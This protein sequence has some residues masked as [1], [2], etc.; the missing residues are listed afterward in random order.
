MGSA[1]PRLGTAR[2]GP[3][4]FTGVKT[5][6]G[7]AAAVLIGLA[8]CGYPVHQR[9]SGWLVVE[10]RH[11][12]LRTNQLRTSIARGAPVRIASEMQRSYDILARHAHP[13]G[14]RGSRSGHRAAGLAVR[15]VHPDRAGFF[16]TMPVASDR[17][18]IGRPTY[19]I[20]ARSGRAILVLPLGTPAPRRRSAGAVCEVV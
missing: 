13:G 7:V 20:K 11:I 12:Q 9:A 2:R 19:A 14:E 4:D 18:T 6:A 10:T 15:P 16:E 3:D 17:V 5:A 8:G 1:G